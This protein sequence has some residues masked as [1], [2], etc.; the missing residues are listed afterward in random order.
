MF[1][2]NKLCDPLIQHIKRVLSQDL[3]LLKSQPFNSK[4][5]STT[6]IQLTTIKPSVF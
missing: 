3:Q 6:T 2:I 1:V 4:Q 5:T